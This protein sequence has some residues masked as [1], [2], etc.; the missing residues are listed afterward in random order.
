MKNNILILFCFPMFLFAQ[1]DTVFD[2]SFEEY[3]Y[4]NV[5]TDSIQISDSTSAKK[6]NLFFNSGWKKHNH[7]VDFNTNLGFIYIE[8]RGAALGYRYLYRPNW[9]WDV[10]LGGRIGFWF[11]KNEHDL[12]PIAEHWYSMHS[13]SIVA[14]APIWKKL[15][16]DLSTG[17]LNWFNSPTK[18]NTL[19]ERKLY[20]GYGYFYQNIGLN[21]VFLKY[22]SIDVGISFDLNMKSKKINEGC[23]LS[24]G[25]KL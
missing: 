25:I 8:R 23:Y 21:M 24:F 4:R 15:N 11:L 14:N 20:T 13:L 17:Y 3:N 16:L 10:K 12:G 19:D 6:E 22:L 1:E 2:F 18:S 5:I 7:I 9:V